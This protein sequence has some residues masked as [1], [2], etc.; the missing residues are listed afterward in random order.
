MIRRPVLRSLGA[1]YHFGTDGEVE[2]DVNGDGLQ[3]DGEEV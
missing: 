2:K 3:R 1:T